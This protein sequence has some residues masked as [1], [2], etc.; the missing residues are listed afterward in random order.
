MVAAVLLR[1]LLAVALAAPALGA[2]S[3]CRALEDQAKW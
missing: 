3:R 1:L 2:V